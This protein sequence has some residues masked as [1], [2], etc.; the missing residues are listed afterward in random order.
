[1]EIFQKR[2]SAITI[3]V[4]FNRAVLSQIIQQSVAVLKH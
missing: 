2:K 1:M 3:L 4:K